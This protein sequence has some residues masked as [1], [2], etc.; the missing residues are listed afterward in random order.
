LVTLA[1][2]CLASVLFIILHVARLK[3]RANLHRDLYEDLRFSLAK[4]IDGGMSDADFASIAE[5]VKENL[6]QEGRLV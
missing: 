2:S 6:K 4:W 1:S 3:E 5:R